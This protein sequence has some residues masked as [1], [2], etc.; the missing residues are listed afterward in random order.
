M[1]HII[2]ITASQSWITNKQQHP[3]NI[4]WR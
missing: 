2:F 3:A 1:P 4:E